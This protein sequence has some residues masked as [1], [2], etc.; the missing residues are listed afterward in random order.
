[1]TTRRDG[2]QSRGRL[3]C[4]FKEYVSPGWG[5]IEVVVDGGS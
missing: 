3:P 2:L 5:E 1:M 4:R